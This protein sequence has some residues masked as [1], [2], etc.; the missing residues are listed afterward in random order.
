MGLERQKAGP[1]A[2]A[3]LDFS[4]QVYDHNTPDPGAMKTIAET[5]QNMQTPQ[6][7]V[8]ATSLAIPSCPNSHF[9]DR[10]ALEDC[11]SEI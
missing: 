8:Q 10:E 1:E 4:S 9:L 11:D 5:S 3:F 7:M 6:N 2:A